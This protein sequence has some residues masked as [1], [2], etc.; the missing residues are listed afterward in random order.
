MN[1]QH[2]IEYFKQEIDK[3]MGPI[4][5]QA[6]HF[7]LIPNESSR[8]L[9]PGV[10]N[11]IKNAQLQESVKFQPYMGYFPIESWKAGIEL[12]A[13]AKA[14][15]KTVH[16]LLIIN[17]WQWVPSVTSGQENPLRDEFY[18]K[19]KL[20]VSF[21]QILSDNKCSVDDIMPMRGNKDNTYHSLYFSEVKLR[22]LYQRR[23]YD[24]LCK[25]G[26]NL[27]ARE[28]V[29]LLMELTKQNTELFISFVPKTCQ[30]PISRGTKETKEKM[31][32]AIRILNIFTHGISEESF[33]DNIEIKIV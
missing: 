30:E 21:E 9:I 6:G 27:C 1:Y 28:Y 22:K 31:N 10:F 3:S 8:H 15:N 17:D 7:A 29:P 25:L 24:K 11:D 20:P 18:K 13:Y 2:F 12:L 4:V 19:C 26:S 23:G 16:I 14:K 5:I 32:I 33:W